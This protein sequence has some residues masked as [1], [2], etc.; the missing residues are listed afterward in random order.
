MYGKPKELTIKEI[1]KRVSEW[2][3]WNYYVPGIP[4]KTPFLSP[5]MKD[6]TPSASLFQSRDGSLLLKDFRLGTYNIW[7]FLQTKYGLTFI[8]ALLTV[9]NDFNLGLAKVKLDKPTTNAFFGILSGEKPTITGD[10]KLNIKSR[11]WN[12]VDEE[13]WDQFGLSTEFLQNNNVK[14]LEN[15]WINDKLVYWYTEYDPVYS[16]EFGNAKRKLYRPMSKKKEYRF[17]TNVKDDTWQGK[18]PKSANIL[19]ITK[20][21]K[22]VLVLNILGYASTA[23]Q[24]E[25]AN[26]EESIITNLKSRFKKIYLLYDNDTP[27]KKY[28]EKVCNQHNLIPIFVPEPCNLHKDISDYRKIHGESNTLK[29]LKNAL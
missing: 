27:G 8:E 29:F 21:Y 11:K 4:L 18:L 2:D 26:I 16:Y 20:S 14:A 1:L 24:S 23:P 3:L 6:K 28:S 19:I 9:N 10:T 13:Y 17:L 12:K 5:L 25:A 22:D 7:S 15:Y